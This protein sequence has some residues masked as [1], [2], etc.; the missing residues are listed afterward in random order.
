MGFKV[1]EEMK[2]LVFFLFLAAALAEHDFS[3]SFP[4]D[5]GSEN[6]LAK[7]RRRIYDAHKKGETCVEMDWNLGNTIHHPDF[8]KEAKSL[9]MTFRQEQVPDPSST[10]R[11]NNVCWT[12]VTKAE[13]VN[14]E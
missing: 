5:F 4:P 10:A 3:K 11:I 9:G 13:I 1:F 7:L 12:S 2:G 14:K 6:L 8:K